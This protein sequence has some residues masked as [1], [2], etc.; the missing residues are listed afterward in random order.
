MRVFEQIERTPN[1]TLLNVDGIIVTIGE[2]TLP[3]RQAATYQLGNSYRNVGRTQL[4]RS[5][6]A[7]CRRADGDQPA[8]HRARPAGP[9]S[10][11]RSTTAG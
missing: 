2:V 6:A 11:P 5:E 10:R 3:L 8:A 7:G 1:Y 9:S 4:E